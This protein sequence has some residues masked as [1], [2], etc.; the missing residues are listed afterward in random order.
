MAIYRIR[1]SNE[2]VGCVSSRSEESARAYSLGKYGAGS[3]VE[4][5][6]T[7]PA[8]DAMGICVLIETR[9]VE[10]RSDFATPKRVRVIA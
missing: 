10:V 9:E 3:D 2:V 8:L 5:V 7:K 4:R 6:D 1:L